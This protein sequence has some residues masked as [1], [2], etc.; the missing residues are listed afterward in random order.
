MPDADAVDSSEIPLAL[1]RL[2]ANIAGNGN[3]PAPAPDSPNSFTAGSTAPPIPAP[4]PDAAQPA[5]PQPAPTSNFYAGANATPSAPAPTNAQPAAPQISSNPGLDAFKAI[6]SGRPAQPAQPALTTPGGQMVPGL[7]KAQKLGVLLKDGLLGAMAGRAANE[8][9]IVQSG[10]RRSG[11]AGVG[12]VAGY[13]APA[14]A[15]MTQQAVQRGGLENQQLGQVVA[16]YPANLALG[17][18]KTISDILANRAKA[19]KDL[20]DSDKDTAEIGAM[21]AKSALENA[22]AL[23]ARYKEDPGS[24]SLIDL[25]TGQPVTTS[26]IAPLTAEEATVL[27]KQPGERVPIKLKNTASEIAARG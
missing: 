5:P 8:E 21:P 26:G 22:Q 10:G 16:A 23:A 18:G 27:G 11:G 19:T 1:R 14:Q 25:Q 24:G 20:S 17:Q 4:T 3:A 7:T 2:F 9:A 12:F 15:A 6:L 13:N